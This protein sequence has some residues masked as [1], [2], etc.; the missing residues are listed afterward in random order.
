ME[1][2]SFTKT[3]NEV[4]RDYLKIYK[5]K[6]WYKMVIDL[7]DGNQISFSENCEFQTL[8]DFHVYALLKAMLKFYANQI[9]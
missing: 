1:K 5:E 3:N 7:K 4:L 8:T 2:L 6:D 9:N